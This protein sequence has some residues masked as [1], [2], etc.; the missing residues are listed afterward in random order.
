MIFSSDC[1]RRDYERFYPHYKSKNFVYSFCTVIDNKNTIKSLEFLQEK[2]GLEEKFFYLPNQF[3][4]HK[5]HMVVFK[6]LD[7]LKKRGHKIKVVCTGSSHEHRS[8]RHYE[9]LMSFIRD[10]GLDDVKNLGLLP[11]DHQYSLYYYAHAVIQPSLFEG[12]SSIVEDARAFSKVI[13]LSDIPVHREQN[14]PG[15]VYFN[16]HDEEE[17]AEKLL[18]VWESDLPRTSD[19]EELVARQNK[20]V[21]AIARNLLRVFETCKTM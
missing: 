19:Y 10:K 18:A 16:P 7:I 8:S 3:W 13:V 21:Q 1:A 14:P 9:D 15:A 6:A 12:W 17:L 5:N 11:R 20:H 4:V 2:Y